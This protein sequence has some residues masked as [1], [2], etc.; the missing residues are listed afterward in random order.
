VGWVCPK[1]RAAAENEPSSTVARKARIWFQS[2]EI[3]AQFIDLRISFAE[4]PLF[5]AVFCMDT[6]EG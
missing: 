6:H 4:K 3:L 5:V 2:K 1:A